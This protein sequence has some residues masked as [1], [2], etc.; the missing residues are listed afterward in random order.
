MGTSPEYE[1]HM[2]TEVQDRLIAIREY[3]ADLQLPLEGADSYEELATQQRR[4]IATMSSYINALTSVLCT[5]GDGDV[6][7]W[8]DFAKLSFQFRYASGYHGGMIFHSD[9]KK[10]SIHT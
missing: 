3:L 5:H 2:G 7:V 4:V 10:W 6:T 8:A 9:D 1:I